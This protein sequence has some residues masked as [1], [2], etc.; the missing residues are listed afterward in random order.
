M[1]FEICLFDFVGTSK[2]EIRERRDINQP[3]ISLEIFR[4]VGAWI[5]VRCVD[6]FVQPINP[7]GSYEKWYSAHDEK[8]LTRQS[9]S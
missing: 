1:K 4:K 3:I 5:G 6:S 7:L 9:I 8:L 2:I